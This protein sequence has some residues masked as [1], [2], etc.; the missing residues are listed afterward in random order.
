MPMTGMPFRDDDAFSMETMNA[1]RLAF[2]A[3]ARGETGLKLDA[4]PLDALTRET[5]EQG[6]L[7]EHMVVALKS[8]WQGTTRPAGVAADAWD[9]LYR[10]ALTR[11]LALHFRDILP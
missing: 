2:E 7:A 10:D 1:L 3:A 5:R 6:R 4:E 8:A 11:V 9:G